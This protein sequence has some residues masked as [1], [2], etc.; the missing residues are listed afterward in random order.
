MEEWKKRQEEEEK[1]VSEEVKLYEQDKKQL[2]KAIHANNFKIDEKY[3]LQVQS[4]ATLI[5][6]SVKEAAVL[7]GSKRLHKESKKDEGMVAKK[8]KSVFNLE[9]ILEDCEQVGDDD[10]FLMK[11]RQKKG[12]EKEMIKPSQFKNDKM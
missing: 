10:G 3:K 2:Q 1:F 12:E 4:G 5:A 7:V 6:K 11:K 8:S 9:E